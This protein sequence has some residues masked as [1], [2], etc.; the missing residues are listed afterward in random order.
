MATYEIWLATDI[1]QRLMLLDDIVSLEAVRTLGEIGQF[2]VTLKPDFDTSLIKID[3]QIQIWRA[4][5]G[6][7][8]SLF[9]IYFIRRWRDITLL[10]EEHIEVGG[11]DCNDLLRRRIACYGA[12]EAE[13][14]KTD[15]ADD[16]MKEIVDENLINDTSTP[17]YGS[18]D[19]ANLDVQDDFGQGPTLTKSFQW[20]KLIR[21]CQDIQKAAREAGD[22]TFFDIVPSVVDANQTRY[23]FRT[24][25]SSAG[26]WQY[27]V[28]RIVFDQERGNLAD[29]WYEEDWTDEENYIYAA[30][31]GVETLRN[32]QEVYDTDRHNQSWWARC[33]GF[34]DARHEDEDNGVREEGRAALERGRPYRAFGGRALDT[35]GTRYGR[36]WDLGHWATARFRGQEYTCIIRS[37][38]LRVDSGGRETV[39]A[40]LEWEG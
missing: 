10:G 5:E 33:E 23:Q 25:T 39:D 11:P 17:T 6:G 18:R 29:P 30:G 38:H 36:D 32:M 31:Q 34:A 27:L 35:E 13:S 3:R 4:P 7:R 8:L 22:E 26:Q 19:Y 14:D 9:R 15:F 40:R 24:W 20:M 28:D 2:S 21:I 1:G 12:T 37:V 16:M